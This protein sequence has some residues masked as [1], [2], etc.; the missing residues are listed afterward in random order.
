M[1]INVCCG[2]LAFTEFTLQ[3]TSVLFSHPSVG[4][5]LVVMSGSETVRRT[6][7]AD[8]GTPAQKLIRIKPRPKQ[9][10]HT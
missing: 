3:L 5:R 10:T 2:Q 6:P 7:M 4:I 9:E 8:A 1:E